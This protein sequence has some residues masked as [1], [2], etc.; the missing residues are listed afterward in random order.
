MT[1]S[2]PLFPDVDSK[3]SLKLVAEMMAIPG[4]STEEAKVMEFVRKKLR[5]AGV[6][7]S[8]VTVD[9]ANQKSPL[10][11]EVGNLIVRLAGT[12]RGPRRLL[13]AHLDT[14]P[15]CVGSQPVKKGNYYHSKDPETALG[16]DDRAGAC[17]VLNAI[18]EI[19]RQNL[20]HPPLTLFW[21][22]QE[23]VGLYGI[24]FVNKRMLG[25]PKLCF[26]WDGGDPNLAVIGATGDY[27]IDIEI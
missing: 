11:G 14:V 19:K 9:T 2:K 15:L 7:D 20:P 1:N 24:R 10:G 3:S 27:A 13:M 8:A 6:P 5:K 4:K 17:V 12:V 25:N 21:P 18:L 16:G 22:V 26:N 23:E